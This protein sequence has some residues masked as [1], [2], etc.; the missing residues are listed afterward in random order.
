MTYQSQKT[1]NITWIRL[2]ICGSLA[3]AALLFTCARI[4]RNYDVELPAQ[5]AQIEASKLA[6]V[7]LKKTIIAAT[8]TSQLQEIVSEYKNQLSD[9]TFI[10]TPK[11]PPKESPFF[12]GTIEAGHESTESK[13]CVENLEI[14]T[15]GYTSLTIQG[16]VKTCGLKV[17]ILGAYGKIKF[18]GI[19][20]SK[21]ATIKLPR[22]QLKES[23]S[24]REF[25]MEVTLAAND[26]SELEIVGT[27]KITGLED[28]S[29]P[30]NYDYETDTN[31]LIGATQGLNEKKE[32]IVAQF[33][34]SVLKSTQGYMES[35]MRDAT[36]RTLEK[37]RKAVNDKHAGIN[38]SMTKLRVLG[39]DI[40]SQF[41]FTSLFG[42]NIS[43]LTF[44]L[45]HTLIPTDVIKDP[46]FE[47][48]VPE[49]SSPPQAMLVKPT[50]HKYDNAISRLIAMSTE[51]QRESSNQTSYSVFIPTSALNLI[52]W[53]VWG[54]RGH[55]EFAIGLSGTYR[56]L[57]N[58]SYETFPQIHFQPIESANEDDH[59]TPKEDFF[60][61]ESIV[62]LRFPKL[63]FEF[64]SDFKEALTKV[65]PKKFPEVILNNI[66]KSYLGLKPVFYTLKLAY[67]PAENS[68]HFFI[69]TESRS[70]AINASTPIEFAQVIV[71]K[72]SIYKDFRDL[73]L[74]SQTSIFLNA[75]IEFYLDLRIAH[76][77][78]VELFNS[79]QLFSAQAQ[80]NKTKIKNVTFGNEG[81]IVTLESRLSQDPAKD[82]KETKTNLSLTTP[83]SHSKSVD[84]N[85]EQLNSELSHFPLGVGQSPED[86]A[87]LILDFY[88]KNHGTCTKYRVLE[89][90][91]S[92][93]IAYLNCSMDSLS[94]EH[95]LQI[96]FD[97]NNISQQRSM[98]LLHTINVHR[99]FN[100]LNNDS[101]FG[102]LHKLLYKIKPEPNFTNQI[103]Q[104]YK[105][106]WDIEDKSYSIQ[107]IC[108]DEVDGPCPENRR[109]STEI[110]TWINK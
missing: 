77:L 11:N 44:S 6:A 34:K 86:A 71:D 92:R 65:W 82:P 15:N 25:D 13:I 57:I 48:A 60:A 23:T 39:F 64:A 41:Q 53:K 46:R 89:T 87:K 9:H 32:V 36:K 14:K 3:I 33:V 97:P 17:N 91:E 56:K 30:D 28:L 10:D 37:L 43:G 49:L 29:N 80:S 94:E 83:D 35:A 12:T 26:R 54:N 110:Q 69:P 78:D 22:L 47:C 40:F 58:I 59:F 75:L 76:D 16:H 2:S 19:A 100:K 84:G 70:L 98:V 85:M 61:N 99:P 24:L 96:G 67:N 7:D 50:D 88:V 104:S 51:D 4:R 62:T 107:Y 79:L 90:H 55:C 72:I 108:L 21:P 106:R 95:F 45:N 27:P 52:F 42:Q 5:N 63:K 101:G 81:I 31:G 73:P 1:H 20:Q 102:P 74:A 105:D 93:R 8:T 68:T 38:R 18:G 103:K 109:V 66:L